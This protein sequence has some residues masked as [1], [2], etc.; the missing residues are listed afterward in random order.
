MTQGFSRVLALVGRHALALMIGAFGTFAI[1]VWA[2]FPMPGRGDLIEVAGPL[3]SYSIEKDNSW[4]SQNLA[5]RRSIYVF[6]KIGNYKGRFWSAAVTPGNVATYLAHEGAEV[7]VYRAS[8]KFYRPVNGD[9]EKTW[10]LSVDGR[11]ILSVDEALTK[12][13]IFAYGIIPVLGMAMLALAI[14]RWKKEDRDSAL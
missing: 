3:V 12:D 5:R 11:E 13:R 14:S 6:F 7:R 9:G 2:I 4:F 8:D 10:G 1:F